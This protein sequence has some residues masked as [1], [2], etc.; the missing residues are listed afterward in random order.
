MF[1]VHV[2]NEKNHH[3]TK[4]IKLSV[5]SRANVKHNN[6]FILI[7]LFNN[8]NIEGQTD[9]FKA[10]PYFLIIFS[11]PQKELLSLAITT[12]GTNKFT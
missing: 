6:R 3:L 7:T 9:I 11:K 2:S 1:I 5:Y 4:F 10:K 8:K 12:V